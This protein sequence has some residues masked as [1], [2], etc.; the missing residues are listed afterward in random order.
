MPKRTPL[1]SFSGLLVPIALFALLLPLGARA[2]AQ[3]D[4]DL[5]QIVISARGYPTLL[6]DIPGSVGV[7]DSS[8]F[9]LAPMHASVADALDLMPG[10]TRTG[11][12]PYAQDVS[13]RGLSGTSVV[14]L[15]DGKRVNT[16]TDINARL[17]YVSTPDI[18]RVEVLKGPITALYGSGSVGGVINIIT[19]KPEGFRDE[20]GVEG[21]FAVTGSTNPLGGTA[22]AYLGFGSP[23]VKGAVAVSYRDFGSVRGYGNQRVPNSQFSDV[24]GRAYLSVKA[25]DNLVIS[26]EAI[27]SIVSDAGIPGGNDTMPQTARITY[28]NGEFTMVSVRAELSLSGLVSRVD[29]ELYR[30]TNRRRVR[31]DQVGPQAGVQPLELWPKADHDTWG[32]KVQATFEGAKNTLILGADFWTWDLDTHRR[33]TV[34][35]GQNVVTTEDKPSPKSRQV[36]IGLFASDTFKPHPDWDLYFGA[37]IDRLRTTNE[38]FY[39]VN[40]ATGAKTLVLRAGAQTDWGWQ[41]HLGA[42]YRFKDDWSMSLLLSSAYRAADLMERFK[43]IS[44]GGGINLHGEPTLKPERSLFGEYAIAYE[45]EG[46]SARLSLFLNMIDDYIAERRVSPTEIR[47][48]NVR[49]ARIWGAELS[50]SKPLG[51]GMTLNG[52]ISFLEGRDRE[53]DRP[54]PGIAPM[55]ANVSFEYR[56]NSPFWARAEQRFIASQPR[57]PEGVERSEAAFVTNLA[58]GITYGET[59]RHEFAISFN[60]IFDN[61][62]QNYL[63]HERGLTIWEPGVSAQISYALVF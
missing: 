6:Q 49:A 7:A 21:R 54:L 25:G 52:D 16:A 33:R 22:Y 62:Y 24:Y 55:N 18:E 58:F 8:D 59:V 15:I 13:I 32:G 47:L 2:L 11:E 28:P 51:H 45:G 29:A 43:Y 20:A 30:T 56:T 12:S 36:S 48:R 46:F 40:P 63:A 53:N 37:R 5:E 50:L 44:L 38:D 17:G 1:T 23:R 10:V 3:T 42:T 19:R 61:K 60:N 27:R 39:F 4:G 26:A 31:I 34:R 57:T 14:V 41:V 35:V 9:T